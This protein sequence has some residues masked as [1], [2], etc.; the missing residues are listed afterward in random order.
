MSRKFKYD[1]LENVIINN[2]AKGLKGDIGKHGHVFDQLEGMIYDYRV[3]LE[4]G[5]YVK[6]KEDEID[7]IKESD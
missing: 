7:L 1:V 5:T 2:K 6:V 4:D 3:K